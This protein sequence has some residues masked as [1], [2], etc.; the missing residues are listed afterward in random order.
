MQQVIYSHKSDSVSLTDAYYKDNPNQV[1]Q[2]FLGFCNAIKYSFNKVIVIIIYILLPNLIHNLYTYYFTILW[3]IIS[4]ENKLLLV[5]FFPHEGDTW[6][7]NQENV[8]SSLFCIFLMAGLMVG[9]RNLVLK[10]SV[11]G[12]IGLYEKSKEQFC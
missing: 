2:T 8:S 10:L 4:H 6:A 1:L 12:L 9:P 11:N 5:I 7:N 3:I